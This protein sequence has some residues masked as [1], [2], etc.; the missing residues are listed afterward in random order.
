MIRSVVEEALRSLSD[1]LTATPVYRTLQIPRMAYLLSFLAIK[2]VK[3]MLALNQ[4]PRLAL[5][6]MTKGV[7]VFPVLE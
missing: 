5:G 6:T 4:L 2:I 3:S 7:S 1:Y